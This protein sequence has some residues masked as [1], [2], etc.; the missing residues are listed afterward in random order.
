MPKIEFSILL[1]GPEG[2]RS[3]IALSGTEVLIGRDDKCA[4]VLAAPSISRWHCRMF[5]HREDN[6]WL[7]EDLHSTNG[8]RVNGELIAKPPRRLEIGDEITW[9]EQAGRLIAQPPAAS[10]MEDTGMQARSSSV[11]SAHTA[12]DVAF[13]YL[14]G[15]VWT[16][17]A[18]LRHEKVR[19]KDTEMRLSTA[20][21]QCRRHRE[22]EHQ[23]R[24]ERA[25]RGQAE[26]RHAETLKKLEELRQKMHTRTQQLDEANAG[27]RLLAAK[28]DIYER[29]NSR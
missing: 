3:S 14:L 9:G 18:A 26:H 5:R 15:M 24:E 1:A 27:L 22:L 10:D 21:A 8:T 17:A 25:S 6:D 20:E 7:I 16:L 28:L 12:A 29:K 4:V 19:R 23:L 2:Q 13:N 11:A